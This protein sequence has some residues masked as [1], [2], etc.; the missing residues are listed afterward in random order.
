MLLALV[1]AYVTV[2]TLFV[3][4]FLDGYGESLVDAY[5]AYI[6][7]PVVV[8]SRGWWDDPDPAHSLK[9]VPRMEH[10]AVLAHSPRLGFPALVRSPYRTEGIEAVGV[11]PRRELAVSRVPSRVA[12]GRWLD[13]PG[14]AVVGIHLARRLDVRVGER[15]VVET[16]A[17]RG[18]QAVGLRVVGIVRAGV[19]NVD[20]F[21]LYLHL[22]DARWLTGGVA[23][24]V[25][26]R[27][28]RAREDAAAQALNRLLPPGLEA[29]GVWD[30]MGPIR[31][32][33]EASRLFYAPIL[34]LFV[35]LAAVAVT[36]TTYVSVR[37]RLR[38]VAVTESLGLPPLSLSAAV[39]AEA[40]LAS[41][42]GLLVGLVVGY[43][44]LWY[45][46][47]HNVFGPLMQLSVELMPEFGLTE[48]L[49]TA[50]R[51]VY[52]VH[53]AAVVAVSGLLA[54]LFPARMVL[55]LDLPRYLKGE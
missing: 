17:L 28:P 36:S 52:V 21:G 3:D 9:A 45:T 51:P 12:Q 29:R 7:A 5:G 43:G 19:S 13:A 44:L 23:T 46:A 6:A 32:D 33:Y 42:V 50:V 49:Y 31:Y 14:E 2:A 27:V 1:V 15:L 10:P 20:H 4:G 48:A 18:P 26:V 22:E 38:E 24:Q 30:L 8:A 54:A 53:A 41:S 40:V 39:A 11:E 34:G 55:R 37:E 35:L 16:S 47:T 25:A